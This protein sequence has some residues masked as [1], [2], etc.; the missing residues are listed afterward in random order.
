MASACPVAGPNFVR[1]YFLLIIFSL[2]LRWR[3]P[4]TLKMLS[5]ACH[6]VLEEVAEEKPHRH[7]RKFYRVQHRQEDRRR[8]RV[9]SLALV[10]A[11]VLALL[12]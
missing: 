4:Q 9:L 3:Q 7:T 10:A 1:F 5:S 2:F 12:L 11:V 6:H 8:L